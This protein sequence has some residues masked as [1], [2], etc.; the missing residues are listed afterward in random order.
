MTDR[1]SPFRLLAAVLLC[2]AALLFLPSCAA[3]PDPTLTAAARASHDAICPEYLRYVDAD[4]ALTQ[5]QRDRRH[6]TVDLWRQAIESREVR[7]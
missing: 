3:G 7:R 6:L 4:P 5:E 1:R 2:L